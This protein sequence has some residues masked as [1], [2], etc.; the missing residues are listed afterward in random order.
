MHCARKVYRA[1]LTSY[2]GEGAKRLLPNQPHWKPLQNYCKDGSED[3]DDGDDICSKEVDELSEND[4]P[5]A[6]KDYEERPSQPVVQGSETKH[7]IERLLLQETFTRD[8]CV[9][10]TKIIQSRVVDFPTMNKGEAA[11]QEELCDAR[12]GSNIAFPRAW[13]SP[14]QTRKSPELFSSSGRSLGAFSP[15]TPALQSHA[16][17]LHNTAVTEAMKWLEEKKMESRSNKDIDRGPCT[18]NTVMLPHVTESEMGSPVDMAK[19]YIRS[20]PPWTS[21]ALSNIGF[22]TPPPIGIHL[23]RDETTYSMDNHSLPSSNGLKRTS[24]AIGS[25]DTINETRRVRLKPMEDAIEPILSDGKAIEVNLQVANAVDSNLVSAKITSDAEETNNTENVRHGTSSSAAL[26]PKTH[27]GTRNGFLASNPTITISDEKEDLE[28][29]QLTK[30]QAG[31][32]S[33]SSEKYKDLLAE[34][35]NSEPKVKLSE[36]TKC[37][38]PS[39]VDGVT[40]RNDA[41]TS[42]CQKGSPVEK[43]ALVKNY[44]HSHQLSSHKETNSNQDSRCLRGKEM[45]KENGL[46]SGNE[47]NGSALPPPS[48]TAGL[49]V[50]L[51]SRA[52]MNSSGSSHRGLSA[53]NPEA[54]CE[55]LSEAS[56][57]TL[58]EA[59]SI[60]DGSQNGHSR[61]SDKPLKT[62]PRPYS[63][64]VVVT[65]PRLKGV[66]TRET[67]VGYSR[68]GRGR[69]K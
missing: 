40:N 55:L 56:I 30:E 58:Q 67:K 65:K 10:L 2:V 7:A 27:P 19:S 39:D 38:L 5:V 34:K 66:Q 57:D 51:G 26:R 69:G 29:T 4:S 36:E 35:L 24:T 50:H 61:K 13:Q 23:Y 31:S 46:R 53:S 41:H 59:K 17:D 33:D 49:D 32:S 63:S 60:E 48:S 47:V 45:L 3:N 21:P 20:R 14:S 8:E 44:S 54:T 11:P 18:F 15:G 22:K 6:N 1:I 28:E 43:I 42:T 68:R 52:Q 9:K 12:V 62:K 64:R 16:P 37:E 25:S